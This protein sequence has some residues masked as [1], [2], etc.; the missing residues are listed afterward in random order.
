MGEI[1]QRMEDLEMKNHYEA[2]VMELLE[3]NKEDV[4]TSSGD[5]LDLEN[6]GVGGGTEWGEGTPL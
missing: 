1:L 2:P 4:I 3:L 6:G 5:R